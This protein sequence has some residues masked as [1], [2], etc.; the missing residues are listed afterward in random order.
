MFIIAPK[1]KLLNEFIIK[2]G[3]SLTQQ[4]AGSCF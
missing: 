2:R 1:T 4:K 3:N